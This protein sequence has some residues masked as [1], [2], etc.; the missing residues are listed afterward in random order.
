MNF[1]LNIS[2]FKGT[3][4]VILSDVPFK[5]GKKF[6]FNL[7]PK[8]LSAFWTEKSFNLNGGELKPIQPRLKVWQRLLLLSL[9][10]FPVLESRSF[11][12]GTPG[13][14]SI[15]LSKM[16]IISSR[17]WKKSK[18]DQIEKRNKK[19][20]NKWRGEEEKNFIQFEFSSPLVSLIKI[21][22]S[23]PIRSNS[24]PI[25]FLKSRNSENNSAWIFYFF[26]VQVSGNIK[27]VGK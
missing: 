4:G 18:F 26:Q 16:I 27:I 19:K 10:V 15:K 6:T 9:P 20:L 1:I 21:K 22:K 13:I 11:F 17:G 25:S 12:P 8:R 3:V 2:S 14:R 7:Y 23:I 5:S 24:L